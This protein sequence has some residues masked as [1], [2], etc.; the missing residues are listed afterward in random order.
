[1][2]VELL[3]DS[4]LKKLGNERKVRDKAI[5]FQ[6]IWVKIVPFQE[7]TNNSCLKCCGKGT[8]RKDV[9]TMSVMAGSR[10]GRQSEKRDAGMGLKDT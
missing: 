6:V 8:V 7:R 9:L 5:V 4:F 2:V 3:K 1:M 10:Y